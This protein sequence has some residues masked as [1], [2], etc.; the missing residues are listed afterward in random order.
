[1]MKPRH[2]A[3]LALVGWYLMVPPSPY[4]SDGDTRPLSQIPISDWQTEHVYDS[5][6]DCDQV[7]SKWHKIAADV[8]K[9]THEFRAAAK[10]NPKTGLLEA[11]GLKTP[12]MS[13]TTPEQL[14]FYENADC[15]ATDDPRLKGK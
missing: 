13:K 15:I 5:A 4:R 6:Q 12:L 7:L 11:P 8:E 10:K 2:A 1:M 9:E 3:A 14:W